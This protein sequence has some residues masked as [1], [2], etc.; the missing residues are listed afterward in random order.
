[1]L[2]RRTGS[3]GRWISWAEAT[4]YAVEESESA[5]NL[6]LRAGESLRAGECELL[7]DDILACSCETCE[8]LVRSWLMAS[9]V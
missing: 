1:M 8:R 9:L 2:A 6:R 4:L 7:G 3:V 5:S